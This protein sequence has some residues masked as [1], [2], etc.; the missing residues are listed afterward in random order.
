MGIYA[1]K[2]GFDSQRKRS[3]PQHRS[4]GRPPRSHSV[5]GVA[6][7]IAWPCREVLQ[8][9]GESRGRNHRA[10]LTTGQRGRTAGPAESGTWSPRCSAVL[11]DDTREIHWVCFQR[12]RATHACCDSE[13]SW[14][15][16]CNNGIREAQ[17]EECVVIPIKPF[18]YL[19]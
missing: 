19:I 18:T 10:R 13:L 4:Q 6:S 1:W 16:P 9:E 7:D 12:C 15:G 2:V 8:E 11:G 17:N 5:H 3:P 14:P